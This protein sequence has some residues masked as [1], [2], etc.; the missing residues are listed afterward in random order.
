MRFRIAMWVLGCAVAWLATFTSTAAAQGWS[1]EPSPASV[2]GADETLPAAVSCPTSSF[3]AAVGRYDT[4]SGGTG[5]FAELWD[6]SSWTIQPLTLPSEV[7]ANLPSGATPIDPEL[8][9]VSCPSAE[10][11]MAVGSTLESTGSPPNQDVYSVPLVAVWRIG[12]WTVQTLRRDSVVGTSAQG[13]TDA[14]FN[15]VSCVS[16]SLCTAVGG[17]DQG[18]GTQ[19]MPQQPLADVWNG[20]G[21]TP[22]NAFVAPPSGAAQLASVSC[23][24]TASCTAVGVGNSLTSSYAA[25]WDGSVWQ[26]Q[27]TTDPSG[28]TVSSL[29][30][31]SCATAAACSAV[32]TEAQ[33]WNG[34]AWTQEPI[35]GNEQFNAVSC[36]AA[37]ACFAVGG[38]D[39]PFGQNWPMMGWDGSNWTSQ[40]NPADAVETGVACPSQSDCTAVGYTDSGLPFDQVIE[41][42]S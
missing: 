9:S 19:V 28:A 14:F 3:C 10:L 23:T 25:Q 22:E 24:S 32:G 13:V 30:G 5:A 20:I 37:Q 18:T 11:C 31:V 12:A 34:T 26:S 29:L 40:V 8:H 7:T 6:G 27:A 16:S 39:Y 4:A 42:Y 38:Q 21:W 1:V 15:G 36:P 2:P 35:P 17:Y 33:Q 41:R